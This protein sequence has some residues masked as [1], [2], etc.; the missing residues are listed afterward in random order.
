MVPDYGNVWCICRTDQ[1]RLDQLG[2]SL[3]DIRIGYLDAVDAVAPALARASFN[4]AATTGNG[5]RKTIIW[6]V[7][8]H[9]S[10]T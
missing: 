2:A 7:F 8:R 9:Q 1:T 3:R 10:T 5:I 6:F 4:T